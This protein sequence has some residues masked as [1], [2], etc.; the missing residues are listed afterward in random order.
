VTIRQRAT[1]EWKAR[2]SHL[3][4]LLAAGL[5]AG[6][7]AAELHGRPDVLNPPE[8]TAAPSE[9]PMRVGYYL[10]PAVRDYHEI[11]G[12]MRFD[13]G[14]RL[15]AEVDENFR[16]SFRAVTPLY[17][18]PADASAAQ[19]LDLIIVVG[20]PK[21]TWKSRAA[22]GDIKLSVPFAIHGV[23]GRRL[24]EKV[25]E[26]EVHAVFGSMNIGENI[27]KAHE[28]A[29]VVSRAVVLQFLRGFRQEAAGLLPVGSPAGERP[30]TAREDAERKARGE[31]EQIAKARADAER[32]GKERAA[33]AAKDR[34]QA[35]RDAQARAER[36]A[37]E[38]TSGLAGADWGRRRP[39]AEA[40]V[41]QAAQAEARGD[42]G[43]ALGAYHR[44]WLL[45][46]RDEDEALRGRVE[47]ALAR[48]AARLP[49]KPA[50][51]EAARRH[52]VQGDAYFDAR[53]FDEAAAA[54]TRLLAVAPWHAVG[55]YN[56]AL[57]LAAQ[58]RYAEA[59]AEMRRF[60]LL[61][62]DGPPARTAQDTIYQWE[63]HLR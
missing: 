18:V 4:L 63:T 20:Q 49:E 17:R 11:F 30:S 28:A 3:S 25:E 1:C 7:C 13:V 52:A 33:Q 9:I 6:G 21:G 10:S 2:S 42:A 24:G 61:V 60:L 62:P 55:R 41:A 31:A 19:G 29:R 37:K 34:A 14:L 50:V 39:L 16:R 53:R 27:N 46:Y 51:A 58:E 22:S 59:I 23:D 26:S 43:G 56:L 12:G 36:E 35:Q 47:E 45:V 44:A 15:A 54:Y 8:L 32:A 5:L 38:A 48:L 40:A 57:T